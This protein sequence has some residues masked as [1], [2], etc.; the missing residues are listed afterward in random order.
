MTQT[1][2]MKSEVNT[3]VVASIDR[4]SVVDDMTIDRRMMVVQAEKS[5]S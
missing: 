3:F 4:S 2:T 1:T 5:Q